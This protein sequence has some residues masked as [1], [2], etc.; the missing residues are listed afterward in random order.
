MMNVRHQQRIMNRTALL[1]LIIAAVVLFLIG[2]AIVKFTG[3]KKKAVD[4]VL[5]GNDT[6]VSNNEPMQ[7][8]QPKPE[9]Q[10]AHYAMIVVSQGKIVIE[11]FPDAAPK[12]VTNFVTLAN[13]GYYN[14]LLWH[15][16]VRDFVIQGGDPNGNGSGGESIY[17]STFEDEINA[18]SI[19]VPADKIALYQELYGYKYRDD[20]TSVKIT[21]G[22][23]AM[24]NRGANTN[25]SQFFIVTGDLE[26]QLDGKHT[27]F[28]KVIEGMDV[29]DKLNEVEVDARDSRPKDP[30][31]MKTIVTGNT[32]DE[33]KAKYVE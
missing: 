16:I 29:V 30:V 8:A 19:G 3:E 33:M 24:A 21:K 10:S 9:Q 28:G 4:S 13:R 1:V 31:A 25:G 26:G 5:A 17:G 14:G 12:T 20:L 7:P 6:A 11:L 32:L 15:R 2:M 27:A 22:I 23:V 18:Q